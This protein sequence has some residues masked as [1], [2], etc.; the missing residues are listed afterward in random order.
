MSS[1]AI[2]ILA[3]VVLLSAG[4]LLAQE[5]PLPP[6][7]VNVNLP[8][9][10]PL[11]LISTSMSDSRT[12]ARGAALMLDLHMSL[13]LRNSSQNRIH[14]VTLRVVSQEVTLGGKGWVTYP[15]LNV[16]PGE[17]FP[18]RI[19]MQLMRPSP[20]MAGTLVQ[21]DLDGVLFQDLS[22]FGPDRLNSR[23]TMT[24]SEM[25]AQRDRDHYKRILA[26]GG[27]PGLKRE[28]LESM[29]RQSEVSQLAVTVKRAGRA[30]TSAAVPGERTAEFAFLQFPDSPV[31]PLEGWAQLAGNEARAPHI[32]V[33]NNSTRAV[34][35]VEMGW[36]VSDQ[37][38]RQYMAASVPSGDAT[39]N[40]PPGNTAR[41]DQEATLSFTSKGQPVNVQKMMGFVNQVEFADGKIWVPNRQNLDNAGLQKVLPASAEELRL[42]EIYRKRGPDALVQE[43][44]KF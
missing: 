13:T 39:L 10:S 41:L 20:V 40:L 3:V 38:G 12:T 21:V 24:A 44:S 2:Q 17:A 27:K 29:A 37:S 30:V 9:N 22:F 4:T 5:A 34:K 25:E 14:G 1:R 42:T 26:E 35:H 16:G 15:S 33:R 31:A 23:R 32:N 6:G 28:M 11:G 19:D 43:L 36:L 8:A 7:S 18:V